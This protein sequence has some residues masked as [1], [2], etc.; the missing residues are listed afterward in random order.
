MQG[1]FTPPHAAE[2]IGV[3]PDFPIGSV[4]E[5]IPPVGFYFDPTQFRQMQLKLSGREIPET[6]AQIDGV[7]K[8][9]GDP[10]PIARFFLDQRIQDLYRAITRQTQLSAAFAG[11]ALFIA[12]L[13]LFGLSA[14]TAERRTK[15]IGVR[16][17]MG[18]SS[19]DILKLLLLQFTKPVL[20]AALI[21]YPA[22]YYIANRWLQGFAYHIELK[23]WM[24]ALATA[25]A[26]AIALLT[27]SV[28]S[29]LVARA[30]P[31]AALRYE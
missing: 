26:F 18:A 24:F 7:W 10:R 3:A 12:C 31:L 27:V 19:T 25:I 2:I 5:V 13:G 9:A 8:N 28:H 23:A 4:R 16:K 6:L 22:G 17:A 20:W 1:R 15:E 11:V 21:A 29:Y 30:K 14:F